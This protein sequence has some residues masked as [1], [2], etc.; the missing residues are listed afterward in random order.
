MDIVCASAQIAHSTCGS[1]QKVN[2]AHAERTVAGYDYNRARSESGD[3]PE[4]CTVKR[5]EPPFIEHAP[6]I[7]SAVAGGGPIGGIS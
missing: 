4:C 7:G 2:S 3:A 5:V 6:P 1:M